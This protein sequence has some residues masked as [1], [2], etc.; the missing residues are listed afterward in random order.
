[1]EQVDYIAEQELI[2]FINGYC[3]QCEFYVYGECLHCGTERANVAEFFSI[4]LTQLDLPVVKRVNG[5]VVCFTGVGKI[6]G[7]P[8]FVKGEGGKN[9]ARSE[10]HLCPNCGV[11]LPVVIVTDDKREALFLMGYKTAEQVLRELAGY[12]PVESLIA[13]L[14]GLGND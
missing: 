6:S 4:R 7:M 9:V 1:M 12:Y 14:R 8:L 13:T 11:I 3:S 5:N 2:G 10:P